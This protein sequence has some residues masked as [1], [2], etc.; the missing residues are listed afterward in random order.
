MPSCHRRQKQSTQ[1]DATRI[2]YQKLNRRVQR[3]EKKRKINSY[4][5]RKKN[6]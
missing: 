2:W 6:G 5:K 3:K 1:E 4:K